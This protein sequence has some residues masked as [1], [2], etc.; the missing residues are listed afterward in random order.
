MN[1]R[2]FILKKRVS[3]NRIHF[4]LK[5]VFLATVLCGVFSVETAFAAVIS[6]DPEEGAYGPGDMFVVTIR[7][8]TDVDE[9]INAVMVELIYPADWMK[10]TVVSKGESLLTLWTDQPLI[11]SKRG[12]VAFSGGIPAGYCG[13]VQGDPGKTNILA[14]VVFNIPGNMIGGKTATGP[15]ELP[16]LFGSSTTVLLNDGFGTPGHLTYKGAK[17]ERLLTSSQ[18]KNEWLD[19]V[20]SDEIPPDQFS[21]TIEHDPN[22]FNGKYFLAFTTVDK[23][24]GI[25]HY[26]IREDDPERLDF[27]R[28]KDKRAEF[29]ESKSPYYY[30]LTDQELK[31]RI[32]VRAYDNARNYTDK[33]IAPLRGSY[34]RVGSENDSRG[35]FPIIWWGVGSFVLVIA[36]VSFIIFRRR[37]R[38]EAAID[39][40]EHDAEPPQQ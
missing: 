30:E 20:H 31:S 40:L 19:I 6:L 37:A 1:M 2:D 28:G 32:T 15:V 21:A 7:L 27:V 8:D 3:I 11:D 12:A 39:H 36:V 5:S 9:C 23:Q 10:A 17:L 25:N 33:I 16:L 29:I 13:R 18:L 35:I 4:A 26:E 24:S 34:A 14:R 38:G 22:I